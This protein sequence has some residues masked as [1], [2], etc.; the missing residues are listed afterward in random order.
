MISR[1]ERTVFGE[2]WWTVDRALLFAVGALMVLGVVLS[3]A[4]SPPV[5]ERIGVDMFHFVNRQVMFLPP[6]LLIMVGVSFLS[7][8][9]V[10]RL[11]WVVFAF[12]MAMLAA[13]L[14]VGMEIKG[15]R[16]WISF[17]GL[18]VQPSEFVKPAFVVLS[19]WLFAEGSERRDMPGHLLAIA[20]LG[21]VVG[22]LVLQ[23]DLGQTVLSTAVWGALFFLA[24]LPWIWVVGLGGVGVVGLVAAYE[25]LPHVARRIDRFMNPETGDTFQ[26]DKATEA[27][28]SAGWFGKGPGEGTVKRIIP[29][30]HT[31]FIAAVTAEEFGILFCIAIVSIYCF[32]VMRGLQHARREQDGFTRLAI[33][34]LTML[35]GLQAA[36][37]MAVNLHLMPA[38]GMTLPFIS[39][40]GSSLFALALG[41]GMLLA[42]TR[43]RPRTDAL[44]SEIARHVRAHGATPVAARA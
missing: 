9:Q 35:F 22:L 44:A 13:T 26:I 31:D 16:R 43:R 37:N 23:P 24:G 1:A 34:G 39:Y 36:I 38:K 28:A 7:P 8:R 4:A 3:L 14:F 41:V 33:A 12:G 19:A 18:A 17:G 32:I 20:L 10:R 11:A 42:L 30:G 21:S 27:F 29:D 5:A 25:L 2:W 40:G 6:A 15:A